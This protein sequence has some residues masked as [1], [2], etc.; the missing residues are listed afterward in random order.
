METDSERSIRSALRPLPV[1]LL[2]SGLIA[3]LPYF[4]LIVSFL[5]SLRESSLVPVWG[6]RAL[7][8]SMAELTL[9]LMVVPLAGFWVYGRT[10]DRLAQ[11]R[12]VALGFLRCLPAV[13]AAA[14]LVFGMIRWERWLLWFPGLYG[15]LVTLYARWLARSG[16]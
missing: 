1:L 13:A 16:T 7:S 3:L 9:T 6:G 11:R 4:L 12:T 14:L 8:A 10:R 2:A 5:P 15:V